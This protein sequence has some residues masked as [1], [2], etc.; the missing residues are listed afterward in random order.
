MKI[1]EVLPE[2]PWEEFLLDQT[3]TPFLQSYAWGEF[4]ENLGLSHRRFG[5]YQK[6]NLVGVC[7]A[8]VGWRKLGSFVYVPHGPVF[9]VLE[10][11]KARTVFRYLKDFSRKER[12]D[13]LRVEPGWD[14]KPEIKALF[15]KEGFKKSKTATIQ[16]G[17]RTLLLDLRRNEDELLAGLRKTTRYLVRKGRELG[18]EVERTSNPKKMAQFHRLMEVT[19]RRQGFT[20]HER[21]YLQVQFETLAPR[22]MAELSL[23]RYRG[24]ILAAAVTFSYGD[25]TSYIHGASV[26]TD[27]PAS[28]TLLWEA[29]LEAKRDKRSY[30]DFWGIAPEGADESHP[31]YG[32]TLFKKGFGGQ[33]IDYIGAWDY[34]ISPRYL[35]VS[36]VERVRG[37][38]R[39][40]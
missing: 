29:I 14:P 9:S 11:G 35:A 12:V 34:A 10:K 24:D 28:Y 30:F 26:K 16:A 2:E 40:L 38:I 13:Y 15:S 18:V 7:L 32:Y 31:W 36:A 37:L 3:H 23:A 19:H 20:P 4:Q 33:P 8:L 21:K 17:G 25:T 39:G 22:R 6:G 1:K 5:I 27:V